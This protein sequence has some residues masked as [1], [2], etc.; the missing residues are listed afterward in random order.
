M[1]LL[2]ILAVKAKRNAIKAPITARKDQPDMTIVGAKSERDKTRH[3][4][5]GP[6]QAHHQAEAPAEGCRDRLVL[7]IRPHEMAYR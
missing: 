7:L 3:G 4:G 2:C 5:P 1:V 6:S